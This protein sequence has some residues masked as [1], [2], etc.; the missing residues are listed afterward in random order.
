MWLRGQWNPGPV[1]AAVLLG[2]LTSLPSAAQYTFGR[3]EGTILDPSGATIS[4]T[5]VKLQHL[6]TNTTRSFSTGADGFYVFFAVPPGNYRLSAEAPGFA[7]KSAQFSVSSNQTVTVNLTLGVSTEK[8]S[9]EVMGEPGTL[10][11]TDA[12]HSH[13]LSA[14]ELALLPNL[15]RNLITTVTLA[16]GVQPTNNPRGGSTFGGGTPGFAVTL[17]VQSG[18]IS[19]NG[20]RAYAS[21]VQLDYTDAND[22]EF[23][24]FA[25]AMQA[26]TPDMLEEFKLLTSNFSAE[27]GVKSNAQVIMLTKSG[28]NRWHGTAYDFLQNDIFNARDY[29]TGQALP[30]KQNIYGF[31]MGGP[32]AK[33][34]T[35]LF[36][37]YEG[38]KTRGAS[39]TTRVNLPT[40]Q[41]RAR[42]SDPIIA[43]LMNQYLPVPPTNTGDLGTIPTQIPSP[44]DNYQFIVKADH[45]FSDAHMLSARY[46]QGTASFVARFPSSNQLPGFDGDDEFA[47]RNINLTDTYILNSRAVNEL[48]LAYGYD[49][50]TVGTQN[51][52][53]TPRFQITGLVNFGA[54]ETLPTNR[55]FNVYQVNDIL[56][57]MRGAHVLRLGVDARKIEDNSLRDTNSRGVFVFSSLNAF[58]NAQ[59]STWMELFGSTQRAFR[60]GLYGFFLQDDWKVGRDLTLNLGLRWDLQGA[61]SEA[62]GLIS[63][64]DPGTPG[65]I[66]VAGPGPL[67]SFRAGGPAVNSNLMLPA[68]RLGFAWNPHHGNF[69]L[70]GGYGI[71]W[72]SF[73]F[74]PLSLSRSTPPL[75]YT[76]TLNDFSGL[77][78][79]D[80]IYN[81][82][83]PILA[84]GASQVGNF[85]NLLNFG[86][87]TTVDPNLRNPYIQQFTV[88]VEYRLHT[89]GISLGYIGT[90]GT[91]LTKL[92]P[93][94]PVVNGPAPASSL[95]DETARQEEFG[96]AFKRQEN[97]PGN[98]RL[99][100]RF[101]Q[102]NLHTS[103]GSSIYHSLQAEVRK[104]FSH[105]LQFQA[106]YTW[107]RA[108]DDASDFNPSI[109]ANDSSFPQSATSPA[110]DRGVSDFDIAQ[111]LVVTAIWQVP[112]FHHMKG[113]AGK[114]LDGW[115][116]ESSNIWQT[117]LPATLLSGPRPA[118]LD[119]KPVAVSD[120]NLDGNLVRA[121]AGQED[122]TRANCDPAGVHFTLGDPA[123]VTGISQPLLGNNGTCGRNSI[124]MPGL[125]NFDWALSKDFRLAEGGPMGSGPWDLQ[126]R[127][128]ALNVFNLPFLTATGNAWRTVS[129]LGGPNFARINAA[130]STRKLQFAL[131]LIW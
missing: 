29:L 42:A 18:L 49:R 68:P 118:T 8:T 12:Q 78:T 69:V 34:R 98:I 94:N 50:G 120:A 62:H 122:N 26:I 85:G 125:T 108:I 96:R 40:L 11:V 107:S 95:A 112:F 4:G 128:E 83:A 43:S 84:Q 117:G 130:G 19:A 2:L 131:K 52:L 115:G 123:S 66:G 90:K 109:L 54:L 81:G 76:L 10:D 21:S 100:P 88:G 86:S 127:T 6:P 104:S 93:I 77:N 113:P 129:N 25:P 60:T 31:T 22:W 87:F 106:A 15:S 24:G 1:L 55:V 101:D 75:N 53:L 67:G 16:P 71:Y 41:A 64:L 61:L 36:G 7:T 35:F 56:N 114:I 44:V 72:D 9:I 92:I 46:V 82:T 119:G 13:T 37:G 116:F 97:G 38:R 59:P 51:G 80:N 5:V 111:R 27:Y 70:R 32:V 74:A 124:R 110:G 39:L 103:S 3:V 99:D 33:D 48:R 79:F 47:L 17:G 20:G 65:N 121:S 126:F 45:H 73:T 28:T 30:L 63:V 105:G 91:H 57:L 58:L 89:Y 102:V 23:G 14:T